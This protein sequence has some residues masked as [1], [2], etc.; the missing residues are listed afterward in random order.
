[1]TYDLRRLRLH[2]LIERLPGT[3]RY[4]LTDFGVRLA[5]FYTRAYDRLLRTGLS[6]ILPHAP[7]RSHKLNDAFRT[8][9]TRHALMPNSTPK[10]DSI[11]S[12]LVGEASYMAS[13]S[14]PHYW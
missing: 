8:S 1:M 5:C 13:H 10:V 2:G 6:V 9:S 4:Q 3:H 11:A 14:F 12:S 7:P